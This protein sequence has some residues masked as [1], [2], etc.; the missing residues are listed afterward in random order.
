MF[1][2]FLKGNN[3]HGERSQIAEDAL[4]SMSFWGITPSLFNDLETGF[5]EFLENTDN[6]VT[7]EY[8]LPNQIQLAIKDYN[9]TVA[10]YTAQEP[11]YGV[12][13]KAELDAIASTLRQLRLGLNE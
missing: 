2:S 1:D 5:I 10:V 3:P 12:T 4:G 8:Y 9:Q 7:K 11:W 6:G 13:Y